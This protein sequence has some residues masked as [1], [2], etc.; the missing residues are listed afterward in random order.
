MNNIWSLLKVQLLTFLGINK[1][2]KT[3]DNKE[4]TKL[5]WLLIAF[6]FTFFTLFG[7]S[8]LYSYLMALSFQP[9]GLLK[10]L[11]TIMMAVAAIATLITT[12]Y[13][14]NGVLFGF[15]DYDMIMALPVKTSEII[16][17]RLLLLYTID[18]FFTVLVMLPAGIVYGIMA[19]PAFAFY[20]L[21]IVGMLLT[22][23]V[24]IVI[25]SI[26]GAV[27]SIISSKFKH[28]NVINI[29][30]TF[31]FL[32]AVMLISNNAGSMQSDFADVGLTITN[33]LNKI[34]PL[35][36]LFTN[37]VCDFSISSLCLFVGITIVIFAL[38]TYFVG[39]KF[40]SINTSMTTTNSKSN[41]KMRG[42]SISSPLIA[43]YKKELG[44]Y[45][46]S[47]LYVINTAF[48]GVMLT[49]MSIAIFILGTEKVEQLI[50]MPGLSGIVGNYSSILLSFFIVMSCTTACSISLEGKN[51]WIIKSAP[52]DTMTIFLS[53][54]MVNMTILVP[55]IVIN[56]AILSIT[57]HMNLITTLLLFITPIV[58]SGYISLI[59]I[60]VNLHFPQLDWTTEVTVIKQSAAI[61]I[62][63]L[64]GVVG[65]GIPIILL[66]FLKSIEPSFIIFGAT[67]FIMLVN[68]AMYKYLSAKGKLI[69]NQL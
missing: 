25:A 60:I 37:G 69:F 29:I 62:S 1:A 12:I 24:P 46:S 52:I 27:I 14:V 3:K 13:K 57:L 41:F 33:L 21:Y 26:I 32:I 49:V 58:Y 66:I 20:P 15:K 22:P 65:A 38:F 48:G 11:L 17:S 30:I 4:K 44:R 56:A 35:A 10:L 2:V 51:L 40:K 67:I 6:I 47:S 9:I 18:I 54:I 63:L 34:Y 28:M 36:V 19:K 61:M 45:F 59:G 31:V 68:T 8:F 43:L 16:A 23:L 53:K 55:V 7:M 39:T 50:Q 5:V 64:L 42:L